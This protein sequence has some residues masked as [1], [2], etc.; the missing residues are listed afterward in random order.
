[1]KNLILSLF[2][3]TA[4]T[5]IIPLK[6]QILSDD[7]LEQQFLNSQSKYGGNEHVQILNY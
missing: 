2:L 5:A 6:K 1:M 7:M 4:S 3:G